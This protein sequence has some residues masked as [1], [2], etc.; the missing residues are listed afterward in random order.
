[1]TTNGHRFSYRIPLYEIDM[2]QAVYHGNY[3]HLFELAREALLRDLGFGY[4]E[5]VA[6][7]IHLA[8]VE[9][10]CQYRRPVRYDDL[11]DIFTAISILKSRSIQFHQ[12]LFLNATGKLATDVRLTT[13]SVNFDGKPIPLPPE[14]RQRL[15]TLIK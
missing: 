4:P 12:Q 6:R 13:I 1:M 8:V 10:H 14:L 7:Q 3:F 9:A 5:L 15:E 11:I 2:G